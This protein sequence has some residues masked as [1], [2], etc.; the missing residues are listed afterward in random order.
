MK[1]K[2]ELKVIL[3]SGDSKRKGW[4]GL[5]IGD[6]GQEV[7]RDMRKGL[8]FC[9][10]SCKSLYAD[11]V[12]EHIQLNEDY[13]FVLN[14]CLRVLNAGCLFYIAVPFYTAPTAFK[15]PTHCRFFTEATFTYMEGICKWQ[16]G[17]DKRWRVVFQ[18]RKGDH[19]VSV[20]LADKDDWVKNNPDKFEQIKK[21][22]EKQIVE[23]ITMDFKFLNET[24]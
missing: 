9:N 18:L 16:Y 6:Y 3:G 21:T 10:N 1:C 20:L 24:I 17:F 4:I 2:E 22:V 12:L 15:D 23:D 5:D 8:P 11:Q 19:L 7:V 13:I 14:E